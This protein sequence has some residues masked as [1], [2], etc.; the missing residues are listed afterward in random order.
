LTRRR[1]LG[2]MLLRL[3]EGEIVTSCFPVVDDQG[4]TPPDA[5]TAE[6]APEAAPDTGIP[7]DE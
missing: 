5:P 6:A 4:E 1:S 7:T 2:V 3:A